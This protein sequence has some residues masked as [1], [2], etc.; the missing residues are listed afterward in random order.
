MLGLVSHEHR[1]ALT[2]ANRDV[3]TIGVQSVSQ[4]EDAVRIASSLGPGLLGGA[5]EAIVRAGRANFAPVMARAIELGRGAGLPGEHEIVLDARDRA[6]E[7]TS[8]DSAYFFLCFS[9]VC[10]GFSFP[11]IALSFYR[12]RSR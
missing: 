4:L 3:S 1:D 8:C 12:D 5:C 6:R 7:G 9:E 2:A 11:Y 10:T